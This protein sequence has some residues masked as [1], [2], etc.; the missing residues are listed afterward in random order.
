MA[1]NVITLNEGIEIIQQTEHPI[2]KLEL[3]LSSLLGFVLAEDISSTLFVPPFHKSAMDGYACLKSELQKPL[4]I[5]QTIAAGDNSGNPVKAGEC[6]RIFTG[7]P[8][9]EGADIV[10]MQEHVNVLPDGRMQFIKE[11]SNTN[12][13]YKGED[14]KPG[15]IVLPKG[16]LI[17]SEHIAMM[18][19][20]G[21]STAKVWEKPT[22]AVLA[23]GNELVEPGGDIADSQIYNANG[24]QLTARLNQ[25][26]FNVEYLGIATDTEEDL[27]NKLQLA[28]ENFDVLILTG[29]VSVGDFDLV[30]QVLKELGFKAHIT[31]L[32]TKP[33]KHT[34]YATK[35][36]RSVLGLPGNPV[37]TFVQMELCG[38]PLL[39][40][41]MG[42][43]FSP[44]RVKVL[45]GDNFKRKKTDRFELKPV[46]ISPEGE[47]V[48]VPYHGSA[49]IHAIGMASALLEMP[50]GVK[51][52]NKGD[53]VYVRPL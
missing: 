38:L 35:G 46:K 13:C 16:T 7:A 48:F 44:L 39:Y 36:N 4:K 53:E 6:A 52:L 50:E 21:I 37:S 40:K 30:P 49:H 3:P 45:A 42:H 22:V 34:L 17:R 25:L 20:V 33:G 19:S 28:T 10:I 26:D 14:L 27:R 41:K 18:A 47:V 11:K 8:V 32:N 2:N 5:T 1:H 9:P 43:V 12:I 29:G 31:T 51:S 24:H 23:T 15:D